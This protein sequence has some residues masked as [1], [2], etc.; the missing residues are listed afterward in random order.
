M[1]KYFLS[2]KQITKIE[3]HYH[4][5]FTMVGAV[6]SEMVIHEI[7]S[8]D[9][10]ID[11]VW[12]KPTEKFP[13]NI[14]AT[15]GMSGY[16]MASAP[17][18][19]IELISIL[20]KDWKMDSESL[21]DMEWYW[22]LYMLKSA[23]RLPYNTDSMLSVAHTFSLDKDYSPFAPTTEMC[24][25]LVTLPTWFDHD[26]FKLNIGGFLSK[27]VVNFLCLTA[28]NKKEM[29]LLESKGPE[30]FLNEYLVKPDGTD[31]LLVRNKR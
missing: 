19:N 5:Y 17:F 10:H 31:D 18:K 22:P 9:L 25:G 12:Y 20:P 13:Y 11:L 1:N 7:V 8:D 29:D 30:Y 6:D 2:D 27:K 21:K 14:I 24:C 15:V 26:I 28:I 4:K 3:D 16:T 23:A